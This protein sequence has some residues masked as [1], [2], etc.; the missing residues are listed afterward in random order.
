MADESKKKVTL[1]VGAQEFNFAVGIAEFT[2]FQNEFLPNNKVAP[3]ENFLMK[4]V[5][6][7][8]RDALI[9]LCDQG[10]AAE[11]AQHVAGEFRP[12][13]AIRVKK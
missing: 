9:K 1:E 8:Q 7:E 2:A 12:D 10:L 4:C 13:L 11:L 5:H 6:P 3:S